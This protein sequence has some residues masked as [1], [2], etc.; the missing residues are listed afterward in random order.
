MGVNEPGEMIVNFFPDFVGRDSA[1]LDRRHI[2]SDV[3]FPAVPR[4]YD[5]SGTAARKKAAIWSIGFWGC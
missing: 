5:S 2:H 1:E 4:V 3:H